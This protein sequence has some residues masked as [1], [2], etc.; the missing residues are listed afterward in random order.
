MKNHVVNWLGSTCLFGMSL[1]T[2]WLSVKLLDIGWDTALLAQILWLVSVSRWHQPSATWP[3]SEI[4]TTSTLRE[5][6]R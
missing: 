6:E 4:S 2:A 1:F 5:N 3:Q